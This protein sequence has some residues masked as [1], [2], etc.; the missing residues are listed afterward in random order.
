MGWSLVRFLRQ[1]R[2]LVRPEYQT[3]RNR[4]YDDDC[5]F[6]YRYNGES[7][8]SSRSLTAVQLCLVKIHNGVAADRREHLRCILDDFTYQLRSKFRS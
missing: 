6:L 3:W 5:G 7:G 8:G 4:V 1:T 2:F